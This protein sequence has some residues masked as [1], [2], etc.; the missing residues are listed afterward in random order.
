MLIPHHKVFALLF[1][2]LCNPFEKDHYD[3]RSALLL[4]VWQTRYY[5][6]QKSP[7]HNKLYSMK[8]Q[9][10]CCQRSLKSLSVTCCPCAFWERSNCEITYVWMF[11]I[12][13]CAHL[14]SSN[15]FMQCSNKALLAHHYHQAYDG[16]GNVRR[17]LCFARYIFISFPEDSVLFLKATFVKQTPQPCLELLIPLSSR[18][19]NQWHCDQLRRL[20]LVLYHLAFIFLSPTQWA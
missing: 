3:H 2:C 16:G 11:I 14:G 17:L 13:S 15:F 8:V 12:F 9:K 1:L 4:A 5:N 6:T 7:I 20:L 18:S 19:P 10:L